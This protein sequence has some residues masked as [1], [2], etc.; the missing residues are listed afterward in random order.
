MTTL[1]ALWTAVFCGV[2]AT[3]AAQDTKAPATRTQTKTDAK[4]PVTVTTKTPAPKQGVA[5]PAT[6]Q[7]AKAPTTKQ[8]TKA[9][10]S[11]QGGTNAPALGTKA[12]GTQ[13]PP[14]LAVAPETAERPRAPV[15]MREVFDYSAEG[16][17]DPFFS[18]LTT[19]E[20]R[21]NVADLTL[22]GVL[23]DARRPIAVM[24][25]AG[26]NTQYRVTVGMMLGRMR[27]AEIKRRTVIFSIEEFGLNRLD[28][29]MLGDTTKARA[30]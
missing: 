27:V 22:V 23:L 7:D 5:V 13:R 26:T 3:A 17:R 19:A 30:R 8:V 12:P 20:L 15:I 25:E 24:R 9:P 10:A 16:R 2:A 4:V 21:P 1:R 6:K 14:A 28:S 29:L 18:L 11:T